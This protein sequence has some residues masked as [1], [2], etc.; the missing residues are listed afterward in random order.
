MKFIK[1]HGEEH[2]R[3]G[4]HFF[5]NARYIRA[6]IFDEIVVQLEYVDQGTPEESI[7]FLVKGIVYSQ[8]KPS[9]CAHQ[10]IITEFDTYKAA[11]KYLDELIEE[12]EESE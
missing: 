9:V 2:Y 5:D 8:D 10:Y 11:E 6:E 4:N 7:A 1:V 3:I 12:L